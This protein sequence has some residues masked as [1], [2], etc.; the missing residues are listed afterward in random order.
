MPEPDRAYG[1]RLT[2]EFTQA[3]P[4]EGSRDVGSPPASLGAVDATFDVLQIRARLT[5]STRAG[6]PRMPPIPLPGR[7]EALSALSPRATG[8]GQL[9]SVRHRLPDYPVR[10]TCSCRDWSRPH[11]ALYEGTEEGDGA[12]W[13]EHVTDE[14]YKA[15][16]AAVEID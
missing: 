6:H 14:Q 2:A 4:A 16:V 15:A 9:R 3:E 1:A 5:G 8:H 10:M 12:S 13:L 7:N 11:I